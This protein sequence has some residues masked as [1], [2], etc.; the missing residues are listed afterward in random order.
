ADLEGES[1]LEASLSVNPL[2]VMVVKQFSFLNAPL[3]LS[4]SFASLWVVYLDYVFTYNMDADL[5]DTLYQM[6]VG[7]GHH[8]RALNG[9][10]L[11]GWPMLSNG[12]FY[13]AT[14]VFTLG[15][16]F[17]GTGYH[18]WN[19]LRTAVFLVH[20]IFVGR[21]LRLTLALLDLPRTPAAS[22]LARSARETLVGGRSCGSPWLHLGDRQRP[23]PR[24]LLAALA[25]PEA[26]SVAHCPSDVRPRRPGLC[27][28]AS[29]CSP[30]SPGLRRQRHAISERSQTGAFKPDFLCQ[31]K[32]K[33]KTKTVIAIAILDAYLLSLLL[34]DKAIQQSEATTG[35]AAAA[36][37]F[38]VTFAALDLLLISYAAW[39]TIRE[40]L[41]SL[42]VVLLSSLVAN[43]HIDQLNGQLRTAVQFRQRQLAVF[44][45]RYLDYFYAEYLRLLRY[46]GALN[47]AVAR[48]LMLIAVIS[49]LSLNVLLLGNLFFR[50]QTA[51]VKG[52]EHLLGLVFITVQ[53]TLAGAGSL[54]L[55]TW[56]DA[57]RRSQ[58][59]LYTVQ[60]KVL[61]IKEGELLYRRSLIIT[62]KLK[63]NAFYEQ[64]CTT[65]VFHFTVGHLGA[66]SRKSL[67]DFVIVYS[68]F[69]MYVAKMVRRGTL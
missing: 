18:L 62:A 34:T 49:N 33:T 50:R 54:V 35:A 66:V 44:K 1:A 17:N 20:L 5:L 52:S 7:N 58:G 30:G 43:R 42:N 53:T 9:R 16:H 65:K 23:P 60:L 48:W 25:R 67:L 31:T 38:L 61:A 57:F 40:T 36:A 37:A 14:A 8:F 46:A 13:I 59:L 63:L 21:F 24:T 2:I 51:T 45:Y 39:K 19:G 6:I 22:G 56:S 27:S 11:G 32:T 12:S 55:S 68:G 3:L 10:Q 41:F 28:P 64:V 4:I 26:A 29:Q 15:P 47:R 69:V